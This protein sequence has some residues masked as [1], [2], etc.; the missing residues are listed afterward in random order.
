MQEDYNRHI[1]EAA[2]SH[3][4]LQ[5]CPVLSI[6]KILNGSWKET[7]SFKRVQDLKNQTI[8]N[9][10]HTTGQTFPEN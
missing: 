5:S 1:S 2:G 7:A 4:N 3:Y 10:T 6:G 8:L 9:G